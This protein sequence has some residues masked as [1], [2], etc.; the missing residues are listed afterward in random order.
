V[1]ESAEAT[2]DPTVAPPPSTKSVESTDSPGAPDPQTLKV[3]FINT[4]DVWVWE[5][6]LSPRRLTSRGQ[7]EELVISSDGLWVAFEWQDPARA[8]SEL[9]VINTSTGDEQLLLS[10]ADLD[11]LYPLEDAL[12]FAPFQFEFLPGTH[13][14][15]VN[16]YRIFEGPGL[17]KNDD[18]WSIE[19]ESGSRTM[20]LEPGQGGDFV[21]A[22]NGEMLALVKPTS[23]GFVR[24]DGSGLS[25]DHL[26]FPFV[27][28]YSEYAYYPVPVW[29]PASDSV[30]VLIPAEDPLADD[31]ARIWNVPATSDPS[32]LVLD[33]G[34]FTFFRNS[35]PI[36]LIAP[37]LSSVAYFHD[38]GGTSAELHLAALDGSS[39]VIYETGSLTWHGWNPNAQDFVYGS[40]PKNL[41]LGR[42]GAPPAGLG[43]GNLLRWIERD[44]FLYLDQL[45]ATHRFV[46]ATISGASTVLDEI[47]GVRFEYD[48]TR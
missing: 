16:T 9:W 7:I 29:S 36:P 26:T 33:L 3:A 5:E 40:A 35:G 45:T 34:S 17:V 47:S 28:T 11:L 22:P 44:E 31:T 12:H 23:I 37:D 2:D 38:A 4:G 30:M 39:N 13:T 1:I 10:Q 24:S 14:L 8:L 21:I 19:V 6:G 20:L 48:F 27:I 25:P 32:T 41:I 43:F 15:L 46:L 42:V 18:L